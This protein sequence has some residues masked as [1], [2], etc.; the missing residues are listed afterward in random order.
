MGEPARADLDRSG[1]ARYRRERLH[2]PGREGEGRAG[3]CRVRQGRKRQ[4][5]GEGADEDELNGSLKLPLI[6]AQAGIHKRTGSPLSIGAFT[7]VH[8]PSKT[9]V[10]ALKDRLW[11]RTKP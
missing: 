9:G 7:P 4:G 5:P 11:G 2:P 10:D 3:E 6:P 1:D 8:S